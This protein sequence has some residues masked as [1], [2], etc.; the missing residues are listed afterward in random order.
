MQKAILALKILILLIFLIIGFYFF[1]ELNKLSNEVEKALVIIEE[2]KIYMPKIEEV[3]EN[4]DNLEPLFESLSRL[5]EIIS[6]LT[7]PLGSEG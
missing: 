3:I 2:I 5:S 4:L 1:N 6:L 7:D